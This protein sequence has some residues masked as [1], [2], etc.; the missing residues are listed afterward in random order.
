[1]LRAVIVPAPQSVL[2]FSPTDTGRT[3]GSLFLPL[4]K[5]KRL[6]APNRVAG[7]SASSA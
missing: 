3:T 6:K 4:P 7:S 2:K 1:M 5:S